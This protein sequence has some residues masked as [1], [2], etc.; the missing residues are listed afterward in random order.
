MNDSY[1][2]TVF[3]PTYNRAHLIE[4]LYA[5]LCRQS[6]RDFEWLVVDDG[7]T[8]DTEALFT[9]LKEDADFS[10]RYYKKENGGKHTAIN[11][12]LELAQGELFFTVD[13]DDYLTDDALEKVARWESELPKNP[14]FCG[15]AGRLADTS[16]RLSGMVSEGTW[17]DGSTLDRYG[18]AGGERAMVFYTE[19][20]KKYP[21]PVF[22]EERFLT[23]AVTWNRMARDGYRFRFYNEV[24][25]IYEYQSD[26]LTGTGMSL[27]Q[28]NPRGYA[29]WIREKADIQGVRGWDRFMTF[30]S[31][32]C[33]M[34]DLCSPSQ[35]AAYLDIP[36]TYIHLILTVHRL[37]HIRRH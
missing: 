34:K 3:T 13:S 11:L 26:G 33:E 1:K 9:R 28:R 23:E 16:G 7:S 24:I 14:R 17:F 4:T 12:G 20:H 29:L 31:F 27:Y 25:W 19:I 18:I 22:P 6:Y 36:A 35:L 2:I 5:S 8:D 32:C 10:V 15:F 30:Y 21:Y 37:K